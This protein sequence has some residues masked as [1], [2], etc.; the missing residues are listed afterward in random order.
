M[1]CVGRL[2]TP[3]KNE[4]QQINYMKRCGISFYGTLV[5][6]HP[7]LKISRRCSSM[8]R[9]RTPKTGKI[10]EAG[11]CRDTS[12]SLVS[13]VCNLI[14]RAHSKITSGICLLGR[15]ERDPLHKNIRTKPLKQKSYVAN[16]QAY[17][18]GRIL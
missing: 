14:P 1:E 17:H 8:W 15:N 9:A 4:A 16:K 2:T 6:S 12:S 11:G 7:I 18:K 13:C 10:W 3:R 5:C